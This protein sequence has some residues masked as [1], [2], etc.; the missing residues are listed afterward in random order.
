MPKSKTSE[1]AEL[2]SNMPVNKI[3]L[4]VYQQIASK[5][6]KK[7]LK[8]LHVWNWCNF[9]ILVEMQLSRVFTILWPESVLHADD[10]YGG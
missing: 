3:P 4:G 1:I 9:N 10:G 8:I 2:Y 5:N 7:S 6:A